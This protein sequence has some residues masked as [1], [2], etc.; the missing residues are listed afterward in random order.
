MSCGCVTNISVTTLLT[1]SIYYFVLYFVYGPCGILHLTRASLRCC[2][3]SF[4]RPWCGANSFGPIGKC[5]YDTV[6]GR[7]TMMTIPL[8]VLFNIGWFAVHLYAEGIVCLWFDQG[9]KKRDSP[10]LQ[11]PSTVNLILGSILF[12]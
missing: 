3:S 4:K 12:I 8:Q 9:I 7:K 1:V 11:I 6:L 2:N 5:T 10:I